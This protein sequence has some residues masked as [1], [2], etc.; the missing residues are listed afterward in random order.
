VGPFLSTAN[1]VA[2]TKGDIVSQAE[3][4]IFR[5]RVLE[6]NPGCR[7]IET[8][9]LTGKGAAELSK[10]FTEAA[11]FDYSEERLKHNAPFSI[12]TL[13]VGETRIHQKHH[14]GVIRHIDGIQEYI[15]E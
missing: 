6:M 3:R 4:E 2:I 8:N 13:C 15:G 12:C 9:G 10:C 5:E 14:R 1:V 7:I 11:G